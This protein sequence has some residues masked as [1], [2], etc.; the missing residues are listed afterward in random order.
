MPGVAPH[1]KTFDALANRSSRWVGEITALHV[2]LTSSNP[3]SLT[4]R[5][6]QGVG[7]VS[8]GPGSECPAEIEFDHS[9][10]V[11]SADFRPVL[12]LR[13]RW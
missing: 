6:V 4:A 9:G 12:L 8:I 13:F 2:T 11:Q 3:M 1:T 10:Q 7:L 5:S